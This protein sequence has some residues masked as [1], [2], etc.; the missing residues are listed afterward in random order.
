[1]Q[2][3]KPILK[4]KKLT[5]KAILPK[6]GS[7]LA[8]GYDLYSIENKEILSGCKAIVKTG[9]AIEIPHGN[10]ARIAPRSGLAAKYMIDV[11]A[12]VIDEDYRGESCIINS[13][14]SF[15]WNCTL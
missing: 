13:C 10:Y 11:G 1:M 8:A 14:L 5:D 7:Q 4:V 2:S 12:G 6:L 3:S 9:I 15:S